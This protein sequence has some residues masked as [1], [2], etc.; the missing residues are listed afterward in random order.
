MFPSRPSGRLRRS[1]A[2][3]TFVYSA[4]YHALLYRRAGAF[5]DRD[6]VS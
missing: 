2:G 3:V 1:L 5:L 4:G 6:A